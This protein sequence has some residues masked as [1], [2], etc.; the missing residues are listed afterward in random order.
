M[1]NPGPPKPLRRPVGI[2]RLGKEGA[3]SDGTSLETA[4]ETCQT[5][6]KLR[7]NERSFFAIGEWANHCRFELIVSA[8][9]GLFRF[10]G[11]VV[12][13][14]YAVEVFG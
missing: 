1:T 12:P 7:T 8:I 14:E 11:Y 2:S 3:N 9:E 10:I 5:R 13:L 4:L 6:N